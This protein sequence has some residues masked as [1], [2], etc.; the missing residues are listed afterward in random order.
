MYIV[1][2]E[3]EESHFTV[4][5]ILMQP[6][7]VEA[8]VYSVTGAIVPWERM[9]TKALVHQLELEWAMAASEGMHIDAP[10][11]DEDPHGWWLRVLT[12]EKL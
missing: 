10:P 3:H 7:D 2:V 11:E 9:E 5:S 6:L 8:F 4:V 1:M 12:E